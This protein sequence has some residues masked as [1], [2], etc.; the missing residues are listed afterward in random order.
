MI[1]KLD[2]LCEQ[3]L[4]HIVLTC[5]LHVQVCSSL[6]CQTSLIPTYL[7]EGIKI[8]ALFEK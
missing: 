2:M 3:A 6:V 8:K 7:L 4:I 1:A 5:Y